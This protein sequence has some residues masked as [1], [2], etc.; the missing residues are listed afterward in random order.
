MRIKDMA[1]IHNVGI[2][3]DKDSHIEERSAVDGL[4]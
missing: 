2:K 4:S 1:N 3:S